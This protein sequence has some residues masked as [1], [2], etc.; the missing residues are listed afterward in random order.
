MEVNK[1]ILATPETLS[2]PK[3]GNIL[4][5]LNT[6]T[7]I[8]PLNTKDNINTSPKLKSPSELFL[9]QI[10]IETKEAVKDEPV[11]TPKGQKIA[12]GVWF[13]DTGRTKD[14]GVVHILTVDPIKAN[15]GAEFSEK[16]KGVLPS[17]FKND[18]NFI[19]AINGQFFADA[20]TIGDMKSGTKVYKDEKI[21]DCYDKSSDK[22]Y[23]IAITPDNKIQTGKGGLSESGGA[24]KFKTF[25]GGILLLYNKDQASRLDQDIKSG[26]LNKRTGFSGSSPDATIS[27][28]FLG[29]TADNKLLLV[30][31]GEGSD[32]SHGVNFNEAAK[33]MKS[34]GAVEAYTLDGGGSTSMLVKGEQPS[35]TD[36]RVVKSYISVRNK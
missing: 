5:P 29:I 33:L 8:S 36:G 11:V 6:S 34:L 31:A 32:R 16:G 19:A 25:F 35:N 2:K 28:S 7:D 27:R 23:Y 1:N 3:K 21:N 22:R 17:S 13:S 20:G 30:A 12:D 10:S 26:A 14:G 15:I 24:D 18:K 9:H 4:T